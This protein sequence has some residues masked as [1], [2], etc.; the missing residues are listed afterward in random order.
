M[1]DVANPPDVTVLQFAQCFQLSHYRLPVCLYFQT[2]LIQK[3]PLC[4][5]SLGLGSN[6][7]SLRTWGG[8]LL[9]TFIK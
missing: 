9:V 1:G 6:L 4:R 3:A 8:S 7:S 2:N 5:A